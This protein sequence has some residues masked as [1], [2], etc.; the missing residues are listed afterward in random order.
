MIKRGLE[1]E[2]VRA[3]QFALTSFVQLT[4]CVV[5]EALHC[6][7]NSIYKVP[8]RKNVLLGLLWIWK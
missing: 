2:Y 8:E 4:F 6:G 7:C 3:N 5:L 1:P